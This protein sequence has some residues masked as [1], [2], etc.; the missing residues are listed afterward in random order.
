[1]SGKP[2]IKI[3][4]IEDVEEK[5]VEQDEITA[6]GNTAEKK[7][8]NS[9]KQSQ[10]IQQNSQ[11]EIPIQKVDKKTANFLSSRLFKNIQSQSSSEQKSASENL[12]LCIVLYSDGY[13]HI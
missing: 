8:N 11:K 1:M 3:I 6:T 10:I 5:E 4:Y 12:P 7:G 9:K 2:Y 13:D